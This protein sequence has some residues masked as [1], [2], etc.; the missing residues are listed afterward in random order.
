MVSVKPNTVAHSGSNRRQRF[1]GVC[2]ELLEDFVCWK[3]ASQLEPLLAVK[4]RILTIKASSRANEN[5]PACCNWCVAFFA[6]GVSRHPLFPELCVNP[7]SLQ[8]ILRAFL[9]IT[10][11]QLVKPQPLS[12]Y[13][14]P[15]HFRELLCR[16]ALVE[17]G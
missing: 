8:L 11:S 2:S 6:R 17:I 13:S 15:K 10:Q 14:H 4:G 5:P 12:R 1:F 9:D 16:L 7:P 3:T